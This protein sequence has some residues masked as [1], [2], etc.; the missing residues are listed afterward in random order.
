MWDGTGW[1]AKEEHMGSMQ[2]G[3]QR[4]KSTQ[5]HADMGNRE[6]KCGG[7]HILGSSTEGLG[8]K[9]R[10]FYSKRKSKGYVPKV[11]SPRKPES[12]TQS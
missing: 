4:G 11:C 10:D 5:A 2:M 3:M 12:L 8:L 9:Y 1:D 7:S 6:L